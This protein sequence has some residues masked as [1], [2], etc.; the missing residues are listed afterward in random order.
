MG[1]IKGVG[2][3]S[4]DEEKKE[5]D[6][7]M[8]LLP[9]LLLLFSSLP[10]FVFSPPFPSNPFRLLSPPIVGLAAHAEQS[11][12]VVLGRLALLTHCR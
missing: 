1:E 2:E 6:E 5:K 12:L 8:Q 11:R 3:D 4:G 9:P 7:V 10:H